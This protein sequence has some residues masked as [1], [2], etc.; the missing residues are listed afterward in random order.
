MPRARY[1]R[2]RHFR[3][4]AFVSGSE[5]KLTAKGG[6]ET[7]NAPGEELEFTPHFETETAAREALESLP[8][9]DPNHAQD[10]G[11]EQT[12]YTLIN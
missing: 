3:C 11:F 1:W 5:L 9:I 2:A 12:G 8:E 7:Y 4:R 10:H 6:A